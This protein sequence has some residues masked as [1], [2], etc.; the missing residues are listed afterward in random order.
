MPV[1]ADQRVAQLGGIRRFRDAGQ[2]PASYY[3]G[4]GVGGPAGGTQMTVESIVRLHE[5]SIDNQFWFSRRDANAGWRLRYTF[6]QILAFEITDSAPNVVSD[7]VSVTQNDVGPLLHCIGV[8]DD[9]TVTFYLNAIAGASGAGVGGYTVAAQPTAIGL[10]SDNLDKAADAFTVFT[11]RASDNFV[12]AP[13][14]IA[15]YHAQVVADIEQG[16]DPSFWK[17]PVNG[18]DFYWDAVDVWQGPGAPLAPNW[19]DRYSGSVLT[20]TGEPEPASY[21]ARF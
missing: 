3:R 13:G 9:P 7:S 19:T 5:L 21:P 11:C 14:D 1:P 6:T 20:K 2:G 12:L 10:R 17:T 8:Y 16:R 18:E 4:A 15:A